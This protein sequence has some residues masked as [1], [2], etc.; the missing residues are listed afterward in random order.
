MEECSLAKLR[1]KEG[2]TVK[3]GDIMAESETDKATMEFEAVDEGTIAKI[4]VPEGTDGV[5]VGAVIAMLA[6]DGEDA[7]SVAAPGGGDTAEADDAGAKENSAD[8][9][10]VGQE[11]VMSWSDRW[12][13]CM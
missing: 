6:E 7:A 3:S 4:V 8:E 10:R 5:K 9:R 1:V 2:D 13:P 11:G 12:M